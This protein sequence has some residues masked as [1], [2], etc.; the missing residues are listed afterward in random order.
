MSLLMARSSGP[1]FAV[2]QAPRNN[3]RAMGTTK[4]LPLRTSTNPS[5]PMKMTSLPSIHHFSLRMP[6]LDSRS[7]P[8]R[9]QSFV[10]FHPVHIAYHMIGLHFHHEH[11]VRIT[12]DDTLAPHFTYNLQD[13]SF[14][15][16]VQNHGI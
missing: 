6:S 10:V 3:A 16:S 8:L 1:L 15:G 14:E 13:R 7:L 11:L 9:L 2:L 5:V 12:F 4:L